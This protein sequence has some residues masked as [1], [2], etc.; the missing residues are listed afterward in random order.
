MSSL[1]LFVGTSGKKACW[2]TM[3]DCFAVQKR[4]LDSDSV[5]GQHRDNKSKFCM[6]A[7]NSLSSFFSPR[8]Q[9]FCLVFLLFF[10]LISIHTYTQIYIYTHTHRAM[11]AESLAL[12]QPHR[13]SPPFLLAVPTYNENC[14][15]SKTFLGSFAYSPFGVPPEREPGMEARTCKLR[16]LQALFFHQP[17][18]STSLSRL[19]RS[20]FSIYIF[21]HFFY[22]FL[23]LPISRLS[24]FPFFVRRVKLYAACKKLAPRSSGCPERC[25]SCN[26][27]PVTKPRCFYPRS[28]GLRPWHRPQIQRE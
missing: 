16:L 10:I 2:Q 24:F 22:Y 28:S 15:G 8:F 13:R 12:T 21:T 17:R 3:D 1:C 25:W 23:F 19:L 20:A 7:V 9:Y 27:F 6:V 26:I 5:V 18:L 14:S 4:V 11:A